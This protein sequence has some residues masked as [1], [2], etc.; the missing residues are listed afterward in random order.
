[1]FYNKCL[2][3]SVDLDREDDE[4][5]ETLD[6]SS[7]SPSST[8]RNYPL[9]CS[10]LYSYQV[11]TLCGLACHSPGFQ[12][13]VHTFVMSFPVLYFHRHPSL[14]SSPSRNRK[15]WSLLMMETWRT[16]LR[17]THT[18][19]IYSQIFELF[20]TYDPLP[21]P[22]IKRHIFL[23]IHSKCSYIQIH[24]Y[25]VR[26]NIIYLIIHKIVINIIQYLS[27]FGCQ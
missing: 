4:D 1:M 16:G 12:G 19:S 24:L 25:C 6:D 20:N 2:K 22:K 15:Y 3:H 8:H 14:M 18:N 17:Y 27:K 7:S 23:C 10:V 26:K 9:T 21:F 5:T 11:H 13:S